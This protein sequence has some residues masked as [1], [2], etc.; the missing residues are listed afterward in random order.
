MRKTVACFSKNALILLLPLLIILK[1]LTIKSCHNRSRADETMPQ[2]LNTAICV[3]VGQVI[4]KRLILLTDF[5]V[6]VNIFS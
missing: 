3:N 1:K 4:T 2:L 6:D 5:R